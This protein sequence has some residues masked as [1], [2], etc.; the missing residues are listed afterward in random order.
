MAKLLNLLLAILCLAQVAYSQDVD[1]AE[2]GDDGDV[3]DS[4]LHEYAVATTDT[5]RLR[6]C[7]LIGH[8]SE[9]V[10]TVEKYARMGISLFDGRDSAS[11]ADCY[12]YLAWSLSFKD[13][14]SESIEFYK[15]ALALYK[16]LKD[17]DSYCLIAISLARNYRDVKDLK[18]AWSCV[19]D[20]I[21]I[22][23]QNNDTLNRCYGYNFI[24]EIYNSQKM[25]TQAREIALKSFDIAQEALRYDDMGQSAISIAETFDCNDTASCRASIFWA[26]QSILYFKKFGEQ[27]FF[28]DVNLMGAFNCLIVK[29]AALSKM[30]GDKSYIDSAIVSLNDLKNLYN[31]GDDRN[32]DLDFFILIGTSKV[33]NALGNYQDAKQSLLKAIDLSNENDMTYYLP[34]IHEDLATTYKHL[35]DYRNAVRYYELALKDK[36]SNHSTTALMETAAFEAKADIDRETE[37]IEAEKLIALQEFDQSRLHFRKMMT[38]GMVALAAMVA[39]VLIVVSLLRHT[40]R[41]SRMLIDTNEEIKKQNEEIIAEKNR[42][43]FTNGML[44]QSM[45][46]ARRIQMATVSSEEELASV[47]PGALV[48]YKPYE[49][50]SGDW[51]WAS[52]IGNKR[53][54]AVGGSAKHG[55]PGALV[56]MITV[57]ILKDTVGQ[58]SAVSIVS[59]SAIL[60][61]V[62]AKLPSAARSVAAGLTLCVFGAKTLKFAAVNQNAMLLKSNRFVVMKCD[63]PGDMVFTVLPGDSVYAYTASTKE[64]LLTFTSTPERFCQEIARLTEEQQKKKIECLIA[65]RVLT[66]DI[67]VVG[68]KI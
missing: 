25:T 68:I 2:D 45:N 39:I 43:A 66:A 52:R 40:R 3:V 64:T 61:T 67:T 37:R 23:Q 33:Q 41:S 55:V 53:L 58:L 22:A 11:L 44:R 62:K 54:L 1:T 65:D 18:N 31:Y 26:R 27:S 5:A 4:L 30:V 42:L 15:K 12:G 57:N 38:A 16:Q 49:I 56:S 51:Y 47:F 21:K 36:I 19:Y 10:D 9:N 14:Y 17:Y 50:V 59:P 29:Y 7:V 13:G 46:Y 60:R 28:V 48:F 32:L 6:L 35:G 63:Q 34:D 20:A 8:N 24:A